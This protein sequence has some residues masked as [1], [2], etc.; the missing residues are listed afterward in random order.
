MFW[1]RNGGNNFRYVL[2]FWGL[3]DDPEVYKNSVSTNRIE[4]LLIAGSQQVRLASRPQLK[5][6]AYS[7]NFV[8]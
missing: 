7:L 5:W 6:Q 2:L 4:R 1:L 3:H 8:W